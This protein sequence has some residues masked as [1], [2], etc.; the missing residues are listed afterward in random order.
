MRKNQTKHEP[1]RITSNTRPKAREAHCYF[2]GEGRKSEVQREREREWIRVYYTRIP[3]A[4]LDDKLSHVKLSTHL[5]TT[6]TKNTQLPV[7][8]SHPL[9][10]LLHTTS[11]IPC[12]HEVTWNVNMW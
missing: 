12:F 2:A 4:F 3:N 9:I 8:A 6:A 5:P 7:V 11:R 1:R 10:Y